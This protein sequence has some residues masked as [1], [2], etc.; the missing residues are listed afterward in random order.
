MLDDSQS[1]RYSEAERI[2]RTKIALEMLLISWA[3]MEDEALH[4]VRLEDQLRRTR[5]AWGTMARD[6]LVTLKER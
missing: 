2:R 4:D 5:E 6:F 3:R 1:S